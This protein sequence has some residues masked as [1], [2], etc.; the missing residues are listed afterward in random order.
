MTGLTRQSQVGAL[1]GL[2]NKHLLVVN[3]DRLVNRYLLQ[4]DYS[5][6]SSQRPLTRGF[7]V[8]NKLGK[9]VNN[10]N[11]KVVNVD[12]HTK[13]NKETNTKESSLVQ[14]RKRGERCPLKEPSKGENPN[15]PLIRERY[16]NGHKECTEFIASCGTYPNFPKQIFALHRII[17]AGFDFRDMGRA[18]DEMEKDPFYRDRNGWDFAT[19]ANFIGR[20]W[21]S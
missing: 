17:K 6:W 16:P 21:R 9:V 7:K 8:V 14:P 2:V 20:R 15:L 5:L 19:L 3:K 10:H 1:G 11:T 13:E 12:R 4:K 18:I